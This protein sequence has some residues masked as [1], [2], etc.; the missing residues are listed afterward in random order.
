MGIAE[1]K[2]KTQ[3]FCIMCKVEDG[4]VIRERKGVNG[5]REKEW[6]IDISWKIY[7]VMHKKLID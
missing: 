5:G 1:K 3:E 7:W 4:E 2:Q 6:K